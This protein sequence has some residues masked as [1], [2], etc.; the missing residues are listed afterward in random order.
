[1]FLNILVGIDGSA[2]SNRALEHAVQLARAG[3]AKL[4]LMTVAPPVAS[5]VTLAGV[6]SDRMKAELDRW[7][8]DLLERATE[9]LPD[10]VSAHRIERRGNAGH[11][12]VKELQQGRLR[13]G[14]ARIARAR[15]HEEGLLGSV[16]GYVHF[17]SHVPLLTVP[18]RPRSSSE[19][20]SSPNRRRYD[21]GV[22]TRALR[23][24]VLDQSP[25]P[26]GAT[27]ADGPPGERQGAAAADRRGIRRRRARCP[28]DDARARGAPPLVRAGRRRVR[29]AVS[30]RAS[31]CSR[32]C[33]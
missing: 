8:S 3:N 11:E 16:N 17:H 13:P 30:R 5:Y 24:S 20:T 6:S 12:I 7:A 23:L 15:T 25:I 28:D 32:R 31:C 14:R 10:G 2:S 29:A 26:E 33:A 27:G 19:P 9:S 1:M 22:A 21:H 18:P 4:T